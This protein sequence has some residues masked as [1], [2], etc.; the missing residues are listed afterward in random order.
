MVGSN[1]PHVWKTHKCKSKEILEI[2]LQFHKDLFDDKF[3]QRNQLHFIRAML[4][5]SKVGILF[6]REVALAVSKRMGGLL[7]KQGFDSV[8]ELMSILHDLSISRNMRM[9]SDPAFSEEKPVYNSR[10]IEIV[11]NYMNENFDKQITLAE[12]AR[13]TNMTKVSLVDF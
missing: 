11:M 3:L 8:L 9:L 10:R 12:A 1:L 13:L 6:S 5:K 7:K 4:E 2:T